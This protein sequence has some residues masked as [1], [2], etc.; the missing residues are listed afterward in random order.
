MTVL[1]AVM[2]PRPSNRGEEYDDDNGGGLR[3]VDVYDLFD[4]CTP[5]VTGVYL[6]GDVD[7]EFLAEHRGEFDDLVRAGLRVVV[8]GHVQRPFLTGLSRWRR[9]EYRGPADLALTRVTEHP[10]WAGVDPAGLLYNTPPGR[11]SAQEREQVGVAGFYGRGY[12]LDLPHGATVVHTLGRIAGPIDLVFPLGSGE[13]LVHAGNDLMSFAS[14]DRG[15]GALR[16]N[17]LDWLEGK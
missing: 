13:V 9:A 16:D 11:W 1:K 4:S 14:E 15:T 6:S 12:Y 7:Q 5:E 17:L 10:V 3:E 8:N 2:A